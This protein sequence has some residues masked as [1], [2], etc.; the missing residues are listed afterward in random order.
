MFKKLLVMVVPLLFAFFV[1]ILSVVRMSQNVYAFQGPRNVLGVA[2]MSGQEIPYYFGYTGRILPDSTFWPVKALRD[3]VWLWATVNPEKK[4]ELLLLFADKRLVAS[5]MLF[6]QNKCEIAFTTLTKAEKYLD[7]AHLVTVANRQKGIDTL[8]FE[9]V[10][11]LA[12]LKHIEVIEEML[13]SVPEDAQ[14]KIIKI[15]DY[16]KGV[17]QET[18]NNLLGKGVLPL[19]NPF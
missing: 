19:T 8:P 11:V 6:E 16:P 5:K 9:Q 13:P 7:E 1:L 3:R 2:T 15:L 4:A 12:S 18:S 10:L 17:Y 14:P